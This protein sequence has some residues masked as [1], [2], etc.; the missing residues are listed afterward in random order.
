[1][2]KISIKKSLKFEKQLMPGIVKALERNLE[3]FIHPLDP[4]KHPKAITNVASC[5]LAIESGN[6]GIG[7]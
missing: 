1:M 3:L 4:E 2:V 7:F 5:K 6:I